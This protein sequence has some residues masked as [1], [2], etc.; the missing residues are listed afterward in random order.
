MKK[1]HYTNYW[2]VYKIYSRMI[3]KY[4]LKEVIIRKNVILIIYME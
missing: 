2:M 3:K 4:K 1:L